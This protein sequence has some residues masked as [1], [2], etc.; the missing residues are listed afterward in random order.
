MEKLIRWFF[1]ELGL[2]CLDMNLVLRATEHQES[3]CFEAF[4]FYPFRTYKGWYSCGQDSMQA[5]W[6]K[7]RLVCDL[8]LILLITRITKPRAVSERQNNVYQRVLIDLSIVCH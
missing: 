3:G 7:M 5:I 2:H 1:Q 4:L 8:S 6:T